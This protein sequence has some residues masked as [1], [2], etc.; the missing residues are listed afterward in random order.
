MPKNATILLSKPQN[1]A[2]EGIKPKLVA[3]EEN[4]N[5]DQLYERTLGAGALV[6]FGPAITYPQNIDIITAQ[7]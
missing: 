4:L 6:G 7:Q 5:A 3:P 2:V 1:E